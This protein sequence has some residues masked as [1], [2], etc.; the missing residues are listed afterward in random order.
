VIIRRA[1]AIPARI[2]D[3][4]S[5][6]HALVVLIY[7]ERVDTVTCLGRF[8]EG[9]GGVVALIEAHIVIR[10]EVLEKRARATE[11]ENEDQAKR[12]ERHAD[13]G[14]GDLDVLV[15]GVEPKAD[16]GEEYGIEDEDRPGDVH[17]TRDFTSRDRF[18]EGEKSQ[19]D[20]G[21]NR[22]YR[23]HEKNRI[24]LFDGVKNKF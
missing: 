21:E 5:T 10:V 1:G 11:K 2:L 7:L 14:N 6:T 4:I 23:P 15:L 8:V 13:G 12:D 17:E 9:H 22:P 3:H 19:S 16:A 18:V 20:N 24:H